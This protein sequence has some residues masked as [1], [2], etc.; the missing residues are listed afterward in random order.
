[1]SDYAEFLSKVG[2]LDVS[3]EESHTDE[4][5][6]ITMR[7]S[8][9]IL[10]RYTMVKCV[11]EKPDD[12]RALAYDRAIGVLLKRGPDKILKRCEKKKAV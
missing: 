1:M 4:T 10:I 2:N 7:C 8:N 3:V 6:T 5:F 9:R 12:V 11:K